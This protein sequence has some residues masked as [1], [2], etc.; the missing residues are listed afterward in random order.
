MTTRGPGSEFIV[1]PQDRVLAF[2]AD[3]ATHGGAEVREIRTHGSAVYIA[4]ERVLK[5]KRAVLYPFMD[6]STVAK[7]R[8]AC[9]DEVRLNRRTAPTLYQ[10]VAPILDVEGRLTLGKIVE[11]PG[12]IEALDWVVIMQRFDEDGQ[13]DR[14]LEAGK[15]DAETLDAAARAIAA[16]HRTAEP[17]EPLGGGGA[18]Q[19]VSQVLEGNLNWMRDY[20][21]FPADRVDAMREACRTALAAVTP[22]LDGRGQAGWVRE[23]HGD[24]HLRNICLIDGKPTPFDCIEFNPAFAR[25]DILYDLAFLVMDL[26]ARNAGEAANLVFRRYLEALPEALEALAAMPLFLGMRAQIRAKVEGAAVPLQSDPQAA[27]AIAEEAMRYFDLAGSFLAPA[28]PAVFAVGG[29][30]G[31]GKSSLAGALAPRLGRLPG[32]VVLRSDAIRKELF[33]KSALEELPPEAYLSAVSEKVYAIMEGRVKTILQGGYAVVL[34]ATFTHPDSRQ[35]AEALA[36]SMSVPFQGYWLEA[37]AELLADRI[38]ARQGDVSDATADVMRDQVA[39]GWGVV[40][41]ARIDAS[42]GLASMAEQAFGYIT[43]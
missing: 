3:P 4:G 18:A 12:A 28:T 32:A 5:L 13:F 10:G 31:T 9:V 37:P 33:G 6:Y 2:L 23:C 43:A 35:R 34:D 26:I 8:D 11:D 42:V 30:S 17:V 16:F 21:G 15:L 19:A 39:Q 41:W 22:L 25:I 38:S 20:V 7:R 36:A 14:L 1:E 24:L 40:S 27:E 29:P